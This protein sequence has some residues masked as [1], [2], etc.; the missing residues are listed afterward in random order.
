MD[1]LGVLDHVGEFTVEANPETVSP[2]LMR[3]LVAGGVNRVSIGAQSFNPAL[4]K[5]LERWHDPAS[6]ARAVATVRDAGI[7]NVNL[8][9]IFAIPDQTPTM[10]DADLDRLLE[11][12]PDHVSCYS[13]IFEPDTA[14]TTKLAREKSRAL[15]EDLERAMYERVIDRLAAAGFEH[16][17]VSN[18]ARG[19]LET[20][21]SKLEWGN[22][23]AH[24][25]AYW[26]NRN[27]LGLGPAAA[28]HVN[29]RR[30]K[31]QPHL[32]RYISESPRPP[33]MDHEQLDADASRG[34]QLML[35]LRLLEGAPLN[36]LNALLPPDD[37]RRA[38]IEELTDIGML[39]RTATHLRL[40]RRGLFVADTVLGKLL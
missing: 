35:R 22:R 33:T 5:T 4:L 8:D 11:L 37:P 34:E 24:N 13:L 39:E 27:W 7:D 32:L 26:T 19:K 36:W 31:N 1:A 3:R 30:W 23:C 15:D 16:Y 14:L 10:L 38:T 18:W 28:S 12:E 17:E 20:R 9:L 25:L 6:V 21:N 2:D 40:T 29:G